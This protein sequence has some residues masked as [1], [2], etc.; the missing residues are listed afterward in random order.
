MQSLLYSA[1]YSKCAYHVVRYTQPGQLTAAAAHDG[2]VAFPQLRYK[3]TRVC[4]LAWGGHAPTST[5]VVLLFAA[6]CICFYYDSVRFIC[7]LNTN[8]RRKY[9]STP[10]GTYYMVQMSTPPHGVRW[11]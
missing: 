2:L 9:I 10:R 5:H 1:L 7:V 6:D 11:Y 8:L 4:D 3:R